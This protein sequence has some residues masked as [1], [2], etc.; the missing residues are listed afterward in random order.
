MF[1]RLRPSGARPSPF[2][3]ALLT[4]VL[5]SVLMV[6]ATPAQAAFVHP[7]CLNSAEE[8]AFAKTKIQAGAEPWSSALQ[9][10]LSKPE[11]SLTWEFWAYA[12]V[13][14]DAYGANDVGGWPM[15]MSARAAYLHALVWGV[16]GDAAHAN[17]AME[18]LD[19]WSATLQSITGV[20]AKLIGAIAAIGFANTAELLAHTGA[21]WP[22]DKQ[23]QA[24][25]MLR[26]VFYQL[27]K[28][29][30][31][32]YNGNWD[33]LITHAMAAMGVFLDDQAMFDRAIDYYRNGSGNGSLPNYVRA[34]GTTQETYR[35]AEHENMGI[36]GLTGTAQTAWHQGIDLFGYLNNRLLAGAE[37]VAARVYNYASGP[38]PCWETLYNHYHDRLGLSM[39]NTEA[40]LARDRYRPED[41]G[42]MQGIGFGT[43]SVYQTALPV[44]KESVGGIKSLFGR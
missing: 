23:A 41:Y 43:L 29:F 25:S 30:Q 36:A 2:V 27:I 1:H 28:D 11:G 40:V 21:N 42:I 31:P 7:G 32:N 10:M 4:L 14:Q 15:M 33:A 6:G 34:D 9:D 26:D 24:A 13:N 39:P 12:N 44:E 17:K 37:G 22:A 35:D 3:F 20:N 8:L 5:T 19:T 18:I 38:L 16:T